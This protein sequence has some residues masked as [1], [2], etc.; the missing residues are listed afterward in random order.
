M[1][2]HVIITGAS[3]GIGAALARSLASAGYSVGLIARRQALLEA[4]ASDLTRG[5]AKAAWA[6][7][8]V[9]D[10]AS[11][12]AAFE[13]LEAE[14][15]PCEVMIANA[16]VLAF[17]RPESF[18]PQVAVNILRV[19]V[20]GAITAAAVALPGMLARRRGQLVVIS[21]AAALRGLPGSYAYS[22][23]KSA[24]SSFFRS[25]AFDLADKG[26]AVTVVQPG[27][28]ATDMTASNT[29]PMPGTWQ[30]SELAD[31][32]VARVQRGGGGVLTT[33]WFM[34]FALGLSRLIP[35]FLF[36]RA[37]RWYFRLGEKS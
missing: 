9:A 33:P 13:S 12:R 15:G 18:D 10:E 28:V 30:A 20:E 2:G 25:L 19:N 23:S 27:F 29:F 32:I 21:S 4:L 34:S 36:D 24:V 35:A 1:P 22:A 5:G 31:V 17:Q 37:A 16:G 8:D 3:V 7:A 26:V 11:M 6:V 14:L